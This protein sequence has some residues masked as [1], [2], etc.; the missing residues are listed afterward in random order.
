MLLIALRLDYSKTMTICMMPTDG[1]EV[2]ILNKPLFDDAI[3]PVPHCIQKYP[4]QVL[5]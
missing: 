4:A 3:I 5:S 2:C 1:G